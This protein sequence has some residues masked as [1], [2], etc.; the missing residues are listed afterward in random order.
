[1][2][3][4]RDSGEDISEE[5]STIRFYFN[6]FDVNGT[7]KISLDELQL[8]IGCITQLEDPTSQAAP[9]TSSNDIQT[10]FETMDIKKTGDID[11][12]EFKQFYQMIMISTN[13]NTK[14][15]S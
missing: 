5:D 11:F 4:F 13:T 6:M 9:V 14:A 10:L 12:D 3:A 7:G 15:H 8:V 2:V 1:M